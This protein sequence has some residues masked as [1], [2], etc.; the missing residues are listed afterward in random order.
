MQ[1]CDLQ[2]N[3]NASLLRKQFLFLMLKCL[4]LNLEILEIRLFFWN[5]SYTITFESLYHKEL[6]SVRRLQLWNLLAAG[7]EH[8]KKKQSY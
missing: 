1:E 2:H 8:T 4:I 3:S 5:N 6:K 7:S